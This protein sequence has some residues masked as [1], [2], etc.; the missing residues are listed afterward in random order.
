MKHVN[1]KM[2]KI[3]QNIEEKYYSVRKF[4]NK[5]KNSSINT[6]LKTDHSV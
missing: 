3:Y 6:A 4:V 1:I 2:N 5:D